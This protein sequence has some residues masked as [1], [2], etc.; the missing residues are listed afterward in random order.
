MDEL[1]PLSSNWTGCHPTSLHLVC[2]YCTYIQY[3][4]ARKRKKKKERKKKNK[5]AGIIVVK[6]TSRRRWDISQVLIHP[7]NS[8]IQPFSPP[9]F[10][11]PPPTTVG[12]LPIYLSLSL[13][14]SNPWFFF[15]DFRVNLIYLLIILACSLMINHP[16]FFHSVAPC[17][18]AALWISPS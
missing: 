2:M 18:S 9:L 1:A 3:N 14:T 11:F 5:I 17:L 16:S 12:R 10:F 13:S 15:K 7:W 6:K 4:T 8:L